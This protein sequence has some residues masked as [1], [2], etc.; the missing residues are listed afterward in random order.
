LVAISDVEHAARR[1]SRV[2]MLIYHK[3][4]VSGELER[5]C[6]PPAPPLAAVC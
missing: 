4:R 2:S 3:A 6:A 5:L 1:F